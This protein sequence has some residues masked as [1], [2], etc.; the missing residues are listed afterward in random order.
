VTTFL[1][2]G[3]SWQYW[4]MGILLLGSTVLFAATRR[5]KA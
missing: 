4:L 1:Q 5:K 2:L 3:Q